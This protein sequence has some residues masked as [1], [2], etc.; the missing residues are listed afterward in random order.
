M[1]QKQEIQ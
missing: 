1:I